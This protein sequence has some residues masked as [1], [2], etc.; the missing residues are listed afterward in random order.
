LGWRR[1]FARFGEPESGV[2]PSP[3]VSDTSEG[4]ARV[5][6]PEDLER[7]RKASLERRKKQLE[8]MRRDRPT[9]E[10]TDTRSL[11][12]AQRLRLKDDDYVPP[13]E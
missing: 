9:P 7:E 4:D 8:E 12:R 11:S 6:T 10:W 1:K 13:T 5:V 3:A 2:G